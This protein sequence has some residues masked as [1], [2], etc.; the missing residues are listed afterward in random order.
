MHRSATFDLVFG[1]LAPPELRTDF[2]AALIN[3]FPH[4]A[5]LEYDDRDNEALKNWTLQDQPL[6][7]YLRWRVLNF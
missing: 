5:T 4:A 3:K 1:L 2:K 7:V 6:K